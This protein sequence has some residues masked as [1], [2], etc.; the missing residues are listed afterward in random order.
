VTAP[1]LERLPGR[2]E[3]ELVQRRGDSH[4]EERPRLIGAGIAVAA[5]LVVAEH[6][7]LGRAQPD[8]HGLNR[9]R[10]VRRSTCAP[11][12]PSLPRR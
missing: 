3:A 1:F 6:H 7:S 12:G 8:L 11:S 9:V 10:A 2:V 4:V 5:H